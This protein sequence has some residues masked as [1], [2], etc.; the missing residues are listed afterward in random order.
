MNKCIYSIQI[1]AFLS[2]YVSI[3]QAFPSYVTHILGYS[4]ERDRMYLGGGSGV[5]S[6]TEERAHIRGRAGVPFTS[7]LHQ[8]VAWLELASNDTAAIEAVSASVPGFGEH[9][10]G[11]VRWN[12]TAGSRWTDYAGGLRVCG[13]FCQ[14]CNTDCL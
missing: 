4:S 13:I 5:F 11:L 9:R 6:A 14:L 10:V 7:T 3:L 1:S 2:F 8:G 12:S